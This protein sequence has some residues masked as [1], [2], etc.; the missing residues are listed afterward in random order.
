M[1]LMSLPSPGSPGP[2]CRGTAQ[3]R[4]RNILQIAVL[5]PGIFQ[6]ELFGASLS[7]FKDIPCWLCC[8]SPFWVG[9]PPLWT[10][11]HTGKIPFKI[12]PYILGLFIIIP[13]I[14][15]GFYNPSPPACSSFMCAGVL[16]TAGGQQ[17]LHRILSWCV[18]YLILPELPF[19]EVSPVPSCPKELCRA[20]SPGMELLLPSVPRGWRMTQCW[21]MALIRSSIP[22]ARSHLLHIPFSRCEG[23]NSCVRSWNN[24]LLQVLNITHC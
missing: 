13:E 3:K 2:R 11:L 17:S 7:L 15:G 21:K 16:G 20:G 10:H 9:S 14:F 23:C 5:R 22:S 6:T 1:V 8:P 12:K 4:N 24:P 19:P 18:L